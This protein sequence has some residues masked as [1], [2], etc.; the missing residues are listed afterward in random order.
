MAAGVPAAGAERQRIDKWL[1][2]ARVVK[3]RS[4]AQKLAEAGQV[5]K[6]RE[7]VEQSSEPVRLG[8]VLTITLAH[9]VLVLK[10]AGFAERRGSATEAAHLFE[11]LSPPP[12]PRES[13]PTALERDPGTGRPTKRDRRRLDALDPGPDED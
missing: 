13:G 3:T 8:D 5:R 2:H 6:N 1:W 12:P 9:R 10:V 4:L 7:R 11:D